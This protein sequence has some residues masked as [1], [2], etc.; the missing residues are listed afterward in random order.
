MI[1]DKWCSTTTYHFETLAF[2]EVLYFFHSFCHLHVANLFFVL[3]FGEI[4]PQKTT[5]RST[6]YSKPRDIL[7][8]NQNP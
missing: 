6:F 1:I 7:R 2:D 4:L 8:E 5:G 3:S